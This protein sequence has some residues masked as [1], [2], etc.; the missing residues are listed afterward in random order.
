MV[1]TTLR[2]VALWVV[3]LML[4]VLD[5]AAQSPMLSELAS[6]PSVNAYPL[7]VPV[8][9]RPLESRF[10]LA[11]E[12][13]PNAVPDS[14]QQASPPRCRRGRRALIGALIGIGAAA[15]LARFAH[16]RFENEA[17]SGAAAAATTLVL[18]AAAGAFVGLATCDENG[19]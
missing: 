19:E 3:A 11:A 5:A 13:K 14:T 16:T 2:A 12:I 10:T 17:A 6:Q 7:A 8:F 1:T 4:S 9:I 15:P 18:G